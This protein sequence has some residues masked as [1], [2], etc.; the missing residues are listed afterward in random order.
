[1]WPLT[2]VP[3]EW[4]AVVEGKRTYQASLVHAATE[5]TPNDSA[6]L[7]A[8][9]T[10]IVRHIQNGDEGWTATNV[11][12]AYMQR[13]IATHEKN[14]CFT[15]ILFTE[16]L[17]AAEELDAEFQAT[18]K[19]RGPLHGVPMTVKDIFDIKG[20]DSTI[21]FTSF[22]NKS[23]DDDA[24]VV[25]LIR[26]SGGIIF[27]KTN[28]PQAVF[29]MEC[30]NPLWGRT[31]N[32]WSAAHTSG[33]SSG[34]EAALLA[35]DAS[36]MG[37]GND[38]GGSLR[39]PAHFS[40]TYTLKPGTYRITAQ[41]RTMPVPGMPGIV[42]T[43]GPMGRSVGDIELA[44][45]VV[46]GKSPPGPFATAPLPYRDVTLPEKLRVGYYIS[47]DFVQTSPAC[48]RAVLE[49]VAALRKQGHECI[50]FMPPRL[51]KSLAL[52]F[53]ITSADGYGTLLSHLEHDLLDPSLTL[54]QYLPRLP[55]FLRVSIAWA[56]GAFTGD[57]IF[58]DLV[59]ATKARPVSELWKS[60]HG[61]AKYHAEFQKEVWDANDFDVVLAPGLACP[62]IP[63]TWSKDLATLTAATILY[64]VLDIPVGTIPVSRVDP[65]KDQLTDEWRATCIGHGSSFLQGKLYDGPDAPYNPDK[66]K[67]LPIG[68]QIVGKAWEE[69]KVVAVMDLV[70]KAL[71]P[72]GFGP[73]HG[74]R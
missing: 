28:L 50:E 49:T 23:A 12:R 74:A 29:S 30:A 10:D 45:R 21:G 56:I 7:S 3:K 22:A 2:S 59:R 38:I 25:K 19:I 31:L 15:E 70:D 1:M 4:T 53:E 16:A 39:I 13:A 40:G 33:G 72:R 24:Y 47:D 9:A 20:F 60:L 63:H 27:A 36:A 44:C 65:T 67:G 61:A 17:A 32:P 46:F 69:E 26:Q 52:F 11:L 41:G 51:W 57:K 54:M 64:N 62:A 73:G 68:V 58:A 6:Y 5:A 18:K 8:S 66:M 34:G 42:D 37:W 48:Q 35:S 14:N 71:G 43:I 55:E